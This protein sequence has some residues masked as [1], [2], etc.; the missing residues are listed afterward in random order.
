MGYVRRMITNQTGY[1]S[2]RHSPFTGGSGRSGE[3]TALD[4][5]QGPGAQKQQQRLG[6]RPSVGSEV[7]LP[8]LSQS[9]KTMESQARPISPGNKDQAS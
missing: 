5:A 6:R 1:C 9:Q 7:S 4:P 2:R 3:A 8:H